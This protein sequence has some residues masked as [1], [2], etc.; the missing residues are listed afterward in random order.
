MDTAKPVSRGSAELF[1]P[2]EWLLPGLLAWAIAAMFLVP[3][4]PRPVTMGLVFNSMMQHMLHGRFDVDPGAVLA[5]GEVYL[6]DGRSY[7]YFGVFCALLRLPLIAVG[8]ANLDITVVSI[9]CA[10]LLGVAARVKAVAVAMEN[11]SAFTRA[12]RT[13]MFAGFALSGETIQFLAP[14]I[15]QEV[16]S[17]S[18]ALASVFGLLALQLCLGKARSRARLYLALAAVA[19][20]EFLCRPT[21][22]IG[23]Y[24]AMTAIFALDLWRSRHRLAARARALAPAGLLLALAAAAVAG[25]NEARWGNP[26]TFM[27]LERAAV[28]NKQYPDW[29][30]RLKR[31]GA[32]NFERVPFAVEYYWAP[33]FALRPSDGPPPLTPRERTLFD[34]VELPVGS[35]FLSDS[36]VVA[37]AL[38]GLLA[39]ARRRSGLP[40]PSV[41]GSVLVALAVPLLLILSLLDL[42]FRYRMEFYPALD[43]AALCGVNAL[44]SRPKPP[45]AVATAA[46]AGLAALAL[47]SSLVLCVVYR[48][49]PM[50]PLQDLEFRGGWLRAIVNDHKIPIVR[51]R[52]VMPDGS[53]IY[54]D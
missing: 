54:Y 31:Y 53:I 5:G 18:A 24:L 48:N 35:P 17:W 20:L 41:G 3:S 46:L 8:Q 47:S 27:P 52:H 28:M 50:G 33:A 30:P 29:P 37:L 36:F 15:F 26:A 10:T 39:L 21:F 34:D 23:A 13:L 22:G 44:A 38:V 42:T 2:P 43:L 9:G 14:S 6:R 16:I 40:D 1:D 11:G 51:R 19:G 7:S 25:V 4:L 32:F 49:A 12:Q 45:A